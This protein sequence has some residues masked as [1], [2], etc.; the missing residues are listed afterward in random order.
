MNEAYTPERL[1]LFDGIPD[2]GFDSLT[3]FTSRLIGAPVSLISIIDPENDRQFF[4]SA[5][6]TAAIFGGA[7]ETP[8]SESFCR[9]VVDR[10]AAL[11]VENAKTH[12]L[13]T[14]GMVDPADQIGSYLGLPV[15]GPDGKPLGALCAIDTVP[16]R[17]KAS[18]IQDM[19][20]LA[21][22]VTD[23]IALRSALIRSEELRC[24]AES[25]RSAAERLGRIVERSSHEIFVFDART[26]TVK[27]ANA[28]AR[29]NLGYSEE[30]LAALT[31]RDISPTMTNAEF[32]E[33]TAPL[34]S[35]TSTGIQFESIHRRAS[36]EDYPVS[37]RVELDDDGA[38]SVYIVYCTDISVQRSLENALEERRRDVERLLG[39]LPDCVTRAAP[40]TTVLYANT[41]YASLLGRTQEQI[42]GTQFLDLIP[43]ET[44]ADLIA[45]LENLTPD[46]P[47]QQIEHPILDSTGQYRNFLWSSLMV[48]EDGVPVE[49]VSVGKDV[50]LLHDAR[51]A[52][53]ERA[54][55]AEAANRA[56]TAFVANMSHEIRT[57]MNGVLGMA[58]A[59]QTTALSDVQKPMVDVIVSAG[60]E[61]LEL[62]NNIIDLSKIEA[63]I[64]TPVEERFVPANLLSGVTALFMHKA[65]E[66]G[67][68]LSCA[69][70]ATEE[71]L[72]GRTG[73]IRQVVNN[74]V[75]NALKFSEGGGIDLDHDVTVDPRSGEAVLTIKV[76]DRGPGVPDAMKD[77][78]FG[79]FQQGDHT[80]DLHI[81]GA[82]LGLAISRRLCDLHDGSLHVEDRD[83]G[84]AVFVA[85]FGVG[86]SEVGFEEMPTPEMPVPNEDR[87]RIRLLV[88]EDNAM[89]RKVLE[90]L[91]TG[92]AVDT[93][94]AEDGGKAFDLLRSRDF[95]AALI[96]IR[97]P[98]MDGIAVAEAVRREE[99]Q[100]DPAMLL[101]ACSANVLSEQVE[102]YHEAGF[103]R[104]LSKPISHTD[105]QECIHWITERITEGAER[106][107]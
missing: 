9:H 23:R 29:Q 64:E 90:A 39:A 20:R 99:A 22:A 91:L 57:P 21:A 102:A 80:A 54:R 36:G 103:D 92:Q 94:F 96:D 74:L 33:R 60:S 41:A 93:V 66:K 85:R 105:L 40:D 82:G 4:T 37:M 59:L 107:A 79:R 26:L 43:Q 12:P 44:R 56:K 28:G 46:N 97:M 38:G 18:E 15:R 78:I 68:A 6:D 35:G 3:E 70:S 65:L 76:A 62:L 104:M 24:A 17:W 81:R 52:I 49:L 48:Y 2:P 61:L 53:A 98:V 13:V 32:R 14:A 55:Q 10:D 86:L 51:E 19:Q 88:A 27:S 45:H 100:S 7:C 50:T 106:A 42:V 84:G 87:E 47:V 101:I 30:I 73:H 95:D 5:S 58:S 77:A 31:P 72:T 8:L 71:T 83:G 89:N 69:G 25:E 1:S 11:E 16:R 34:H 63:E 67:I 75:S